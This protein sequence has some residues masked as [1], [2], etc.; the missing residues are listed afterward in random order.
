MSQRE[1]TR[2]LSLSMIDK[3]G[4]NTTQFQAAYADGSDLTRT[5]YSDG[6]GRR[7]TRIIQNLPDGRRLTETS[8]KDHE[9][10]ESTSTI[11]LHTDGTFDE[12]VTMIRPGGPT[13]ATKRTI[14]PGKV[15]CLLHKVTLGDHSEGYEQKVSFTEDGGKTIE[16]K[17]FR[18]PGG[19]QD[20]TIRRFDV[21][22][23]EIG[24]E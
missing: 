21:Q 10:R 3:D 18:E 23:K 12:E 14:V 8:S 13:T 22:G 17:H 19:H 15:E 5:I 1:I 6:S 20:Y 11:F 9:G 24:T 16:R 7:T 2:Q 4:K